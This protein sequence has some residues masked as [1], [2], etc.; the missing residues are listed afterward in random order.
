[1]PCPYVY[2]IMVNSTFAM[3]ICFLYYG[4]LDIKI[5]EEP[6]FLS[7]IYC[8]VCIFSLECEIEKKASL[9]FYFVS[10]M[11]L[12]DFVPDPPVVGKV[13]HSSVELIWD[14]TILTESSSSVLSKG[15]SLMKY[16]VQEDEVTGLA[17]KG[18]GTVSLSV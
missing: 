16:I 4:K 6:K 13:T 7:I 18:Y 12:S 8:C 3:S 10:G 5:S 11:D 1:M 17:T 15:R 14:K 9:Y 2:Y